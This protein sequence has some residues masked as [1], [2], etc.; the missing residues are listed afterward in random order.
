MRFIFEQQRNPDYFGL[1]NSS[2]AL[3]NSFNA[4]NLVHNH[5]QGASS[6]WA[7]LLKQIRDGSF[8]IADINLLKTRIIEDPDVPELSEACHIMFKKI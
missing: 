1:H 8:T 2:D 6:E 5:R 3:W 4:V 7:D